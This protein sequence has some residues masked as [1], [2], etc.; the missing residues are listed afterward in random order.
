MKTTHFILSAALS[1]IGWIVIAG[2]GIG[3]I[4]LVKQ[5]STG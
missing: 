2:I 3:A 1:A 4:T 5:C